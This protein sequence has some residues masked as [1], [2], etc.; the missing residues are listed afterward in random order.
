MIQSDAFGY[1]N[2][3]DKALDASWNRQ[4]VIAN[5]L[6]NVDTPFYK[7]KDIDFASI[8]ENE[9]TKTKYGT[10]DKAVRQMD[11][12]DLEAYVYTDAENFSY[13]ID[14]NNVDVDTE[15]V[16]LAS[17]QLKY[18]ILSQSVKDQFSRF[19]IVTRS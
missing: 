5:N 3:L 6:A 12:E 7:R 18:Q 1:V 2:V 10:L 15:N 13:R 17:E 4:T 8:L 16:E 9:I 14:K 11:P 19:N